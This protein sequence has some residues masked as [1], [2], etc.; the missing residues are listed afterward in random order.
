M[1]VAVKKGDVFLIPITDGNWV[2]GQI[3]DDRYGELYVAIFEGTFVEDEIELDNVK[4]LKP[5]ILAL[6]LDSLLWHG[7]WKIIGNYT[8]NLSGF[9]ELFFKVEEN[10]QL[11]MESRNRSLSIKI[12]KKIAEKLMYRT[13]VAPVRIENAVLAYYGFQDWQFD[14]DKLKVD[15]A[16]KCKDLV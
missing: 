14:F 12:S 1:G 5:F 2:Y 13:V 16:L 9:P 6:T 4:K 15:Y 10:G 3:L 8:A 11:I 7:E